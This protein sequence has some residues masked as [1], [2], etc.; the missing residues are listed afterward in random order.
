[1]SRLQASTLGLMVH[2]IQAPQGFDTVGFLSD[3]SESES[4]A[5]VSPNLVFRLTAVPLP[6]PTSAG[7]LRP[8][9][10]RPLP[11]QFSCGRPL[12]IGLLDSAIPSKVAQAEGLTSL[13]FSRSSSVDQTDHGASIA[14]P[15]A[16]PAYSAPHSPPRS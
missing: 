14:G 6:P 15:R 4:G 2:R 9:A 16:P 3:L 7:L 12:A 5:E 1:M 10:A 11:A 8:L 13:R